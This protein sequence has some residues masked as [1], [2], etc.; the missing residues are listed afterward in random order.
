[1]S[2]SPVDV[3][4]EGATTSMSSCLFSGRIISSDNINLS[5]APNIWAI[6]RTVVRQIVDVG[7]RES[8]SEGMHSGRNSF[9][10]KVGL[11]SVKTARQNKNLDNIERK[12][13][14][15]IY[16]SEVVLISS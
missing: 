13:F 8:G 15:I 1:M 12:G 14:E 9:L 7:R 11:Y 5:V 16:F 10:L 6:C 3:L 2:I 4:H